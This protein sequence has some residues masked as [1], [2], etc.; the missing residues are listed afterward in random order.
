MADKGHSGRFCTPP[1]HQGRLSE[2]V[3]GFSIDA[4]TQGPTSSQHQEQIMVGVSVRPQLI[5][6]ARLNP[7]PV[8]PLLLA[9]EL[10]LVLTSNKNKP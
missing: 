4:R 5:R 9:S 1:T 3:T 6:A 2:S 8:S 10:R 7:S